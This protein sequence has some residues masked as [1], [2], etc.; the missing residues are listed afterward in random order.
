MSVAAKGFRRGRRSHEVSSRS[1]LDLPGWG[2]FWAPFN[3]RT[4]EPSTAARDQSISPAAFSSASSTSCNC[5]HKPVC[6]RP[7]ACAQGC[8][9]AARPRA[10]K[11][12]SSPRA[13][14]RPPTAC[15]T[16]HRPQPDDPT[17]A[18]RS[19]NIQDHYFGTS[20]CRSRIE[21]PN[22]VTLGP[23]ITCGPAV[24]LPSF[25]R[26]LRRGH[27]LIESWLDHG[28]PYV[29]RLSVTGLRVREVQ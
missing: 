20:D 4:W 19:N 16:P 27:G 11:A 26:Q 7:A 21:W 9:T 2:R 13:R 5:C 14:P 24:S 23:A 10:T 18:S 25:I 8:E 12:R 17:T 6:G 28:L 3:A 1:W 15:A 22:R 29:A